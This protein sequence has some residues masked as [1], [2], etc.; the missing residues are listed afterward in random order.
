MIPP[1]FR[2]VRLPLH[3]RGDLHV[4]GQ[5]APVHLSGCDAGEATLCHP[6]PRGPSEWLRRADDPSFPRISYF[7]LLPF[8]T[9]GSAAPTSLSYKRYYLFFPYRFLLHLIQNLNSMNREFRE[10][11]LD[12]HWLFCKDWCQFALNVKAEVK[13]TVTGFFSLSMPLLQGSLLRVLSWLY[14]R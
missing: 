1:L 5:T 4:H 10:D 3:S 12:Q 9:S 11:D 7:W 6:L 2:S 8:K 14:V 13:A